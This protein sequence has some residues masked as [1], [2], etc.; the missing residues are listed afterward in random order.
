MKLTR[1]L[2]DDLRTHFTDKLRQ[3]I[4]DAVDTIERIGGSQDEA[5]I[6]VCQQFMYMTICYFIENKIGK[7]EYL[8]RCADLYDIVDRVQ[9]QK[10][11]KEDHGQP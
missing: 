4:A 7:Q 8:R 10:E 5:C 11:R 6:M 3:H 2:S 9:K 1:D